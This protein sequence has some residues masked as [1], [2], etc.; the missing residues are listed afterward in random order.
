MSLRIGA[1]ILG[2]CILLV[3]LELVRRNKLRAEHALPWLFAAVVII[4]LGI[5]RGLLWGISALLGVEYPPILLVTVGVLLAVLVLLF[6]GMAISG[7]AYKNRDLAQ[8]MAIMGW[9]ITQLQ[10]DLA[11]LRGSRVQSQKPQLA[12][13]TSSRITGD[14]N[15]Q[16]INGPDNCGEANE[17]ET[18]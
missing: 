15:R 3:A 4:V 10:E 6:Q 1:I 14:G 17:D 13:R 9:Q 5:A 12:A 18:V 11:Y 16:M 2:V 7:M 8:R